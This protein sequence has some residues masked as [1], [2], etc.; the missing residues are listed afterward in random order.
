MRYQLPK[1]LLLL[2]THAT[3]RAIQEIILHIRPAI[4]R[5]NNETK[6]I[7]RP[8]SQYASELL[9]EAAANVTTPQVQMALQRLAKT[10]NQT[11]NK[12]K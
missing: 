6:K 10:M 5:N 3:F 11:K 7:K 8:P 1:I 9:E 2:Q 4:I 12:G